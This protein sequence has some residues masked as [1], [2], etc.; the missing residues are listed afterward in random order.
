MTFYELFD[1]AITNCKSGVGYNDARYEFVK[2][3][4]NIFDTFTK[5][6]N[7][8]VSNPYGRNEYIEI[9]VYVNSVRIKLANV[10]VKFKKTGTQTSRWAYE[11]H[12]VYKVVNASTL[13]DIMDKDIM[14]YIKTKIT[15][16]SEFIR[17]QEIKAQ[18]EAAAIATE[19]LRAKLKPLVEEAKAFIAPYRE[20]YKKASDE[21]YKSEVRNYND[22]AYKNASD[23]YHGIVKLFAEIGIT[24]SIY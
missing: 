14:S 22:P 20:A 3:V 2:T 15:T 13:E 9:F 19:E 7:F 16:D 8:Y 18:V 5:D 11:N 1:N 4:K 6:L 24:D 10:S 12:N 23:L 21:I 17:A